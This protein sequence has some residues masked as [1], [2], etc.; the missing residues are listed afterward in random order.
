MTYESWKK[1]FHINWP[2]LIEPQLIDLPGNALILNLKFNFRWQQSI[3]GV[4]L[5]DIADIRERNSASR[6]LDI[7]FNEEIEWVK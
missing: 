4:S 1:I 3:A 7:N 6:L 2:Q 5:G